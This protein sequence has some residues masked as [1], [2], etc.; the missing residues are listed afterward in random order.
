MSL[1]KIKK[2]VL[3]HAAVLWYQYYHNIS[4]KMHLQGLAYTTLTQL[5]DRKGRKPA[6]AITK[7]SSECTLTWRKLIK[8]EMLNK[9]RK[10]SNTSSSS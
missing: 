4:S 10:H 7:R 8:I 6:T 5:G 2:T 1:H 9:N 3:S